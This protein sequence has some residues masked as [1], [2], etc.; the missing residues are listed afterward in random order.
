MIA[1]RLAIVVGSGSAGRRHALA[2]RRAVPLARVLVVRRPDSIRPPESLLAAG[3]E[4]VSSLDHALQIG[5]PDVA[6]VANPA[7]FHRPATEALLEAGAAVLVEKPLAA[8]AASARAIAEASARPDR[9]LLVGYHLRCGD[10]LPGLAKIARTGAIGRVVGFD[11]HV[12]QRLEDWRPDIDPR[13]S[14]SARRELGGGVLLELSH[15]LDAV[16]CLLGPITAVERAR[17]EIGGAPTDGVVETVADLDLRT[18]EGVGGTVHLDMVSETST[19]RWVLRGS[20]GSVTADL[21]AGSI[22][23]ID[24]EGVRT[25]TAIEPGERVRA[26]DRLI[27]ALVAGDGGGPIATAED[28]VAA[29]QVVEAAAESARRGARIVVDRSYDGGSN[30]CA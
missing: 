7:P 1:P 21:I 25:V 9:T 5:A 23:V 14:V 13:A 8:D 29:V 11:L 26:E 12:G 19:R 24:R 15:E 20:A 27:T 30:P 28:G 2:L 4:I 16:R 22:E 10:T 3:V 6:V 17:L 18:A